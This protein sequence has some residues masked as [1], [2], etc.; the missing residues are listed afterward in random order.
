MKSLLSSFLALILCFSARSQTNGFV[1]CT[2]SYSTNSTDWVTTNIYQIPI[3]NF[4]TG[5]YR[6]Q[7]VIIPLTSNRTDIS[8]VVLYGPTVTNITTQIYVGY[9]IV[10]ATNIDVRACMNINSI[11]PVGSDTNSCNV[12]YFDVIFHDGIQPNDIVFICL[13]GV[14][15]FD[16]GAG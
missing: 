15:C 8:S 1:S 16:F 5:F 3:T 2:L 6:S 9:F 14:P 11:E 12:G 4:D 7:S 13:D 10:Y